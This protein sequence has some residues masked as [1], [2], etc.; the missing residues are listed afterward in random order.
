MLVVSPARADDRFMLQGG[1][2]S[3]V[4]DAIGMERYGDACFSLLEQPL[5]IDHWALYRHNTDSPVHCI[6]TA[7]RS[8]PLAA[9]EN[10]SRFVGRH[11][12]CDPSLMA[13]KARPVRSACV[14]TMEVADIRDHHYRHCFDL[15]HVQERMSFFHAQGADLYQLSVFRRIGKRPF[16][17]EDTARFASLASFVVA[18]AVKHERFRTLA[19]GIPQHLDLE[20]TEQLL[21][22]LP[23]G[24][25][26]REAQVCAR[27]I[28]GMTI[29][30]TAADLCIRRTSV[31]TYRQRAYAKLNIARQAELVGVLSNLRVLTAASAARTALLPLDS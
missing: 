18:S 6:A 3:D 8:Y 23:S 4:V 2:A 26:K 12:K 10:I 21:L 30:E 20:E 9:R 7:S 15:T 13:A 16:S 29:D 27:I 11:Y 14:V 19:A 31:V 28:A 1:R 22:Q 17:P 24:L 5:N 25:S